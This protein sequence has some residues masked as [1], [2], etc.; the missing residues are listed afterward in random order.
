[1]AERVHG[2]PDDGAAEGL[3]NGGDPGRPRP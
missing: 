3:T 2:N 1:V